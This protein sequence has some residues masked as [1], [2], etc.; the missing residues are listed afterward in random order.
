MRPP[1]LI[2]DQVNFLTHPSQQTQLLWSLS[3]AS[4]DDLRDGLDNG[5]FSSLDLVKTYLARISQTDEM[6]HAVIEINPDAIEIARTTDEERKR[7]QTRGTDGLAGIRVGVPWKIVRDSVD[8]IHILRDFEDSLLLMKKLGAEIV[9]DANSPAFKHG[10]TQEN[11]LCSY[12]MIR[13]MTSRYLASLDCNPDNL[14]DLDDVV[15]YIESHETED[16]PRYSVDTLRKMAASPYT[17]NSQEYQD[18]LKTRLYMGAEGGVLGALEEHNCDVL[19]LPTDSD[20]PTNLAG[21][22]SINIPLGFGPADISAEYATPNLV[23]RGPNIPYG[24]LFTAR[25]WH[26]ARL[27][28]VAYAY[29]QAS[30][31]RDQVALMIDSNI[32]LRHIIEARKRSPRTES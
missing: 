18:A 27:L 31:T 4:I 24:L 9:H 8:D 15:R 3:Y 28:Q 5:K 16:F 13:H 30:K 12:S 1:L 17:V 25:K 14:R 19:V 2:L 20:N 32:E 10:W 7:G 6:L 11:R 26:E 29:E 23:D 21:F 22:P